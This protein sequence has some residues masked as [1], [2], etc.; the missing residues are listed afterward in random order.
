MNNLSQKVSLRISKKALELQRLNIAVKASLPKDC[1][2]HMDVAAMRDKQLVIITDSPVWQ[3]R[4]RMYSQSML[5]AL[6]QYT[7][8]KLN[9]VYIKSTPKKRVIEPPLP[10]YR[11]LSTENSKLIKQTA[12]CISDTRL[13]T[14]LLNLSKKTQGKVFNTE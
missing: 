8:I 11:V 4:L 10:V 12:R 14:A 1:R 2:E 5:E 13:Q 7:G 6:H 9:R 3:T